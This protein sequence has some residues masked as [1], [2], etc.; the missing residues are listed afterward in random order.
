MPAGLVA[1]PGDDVDG[2]K[3]K[4]EPHHSHFI[5]APS[6]DWGG[7]TTTMI[8]LIHVLHQSIPGVAVVANGGGITKSEIVNVVRQRI[9]VVVI[10]GSGRLADSIAAEIKAREGGGDG[11]DA[12]SIADELLR[13][14]VNDGDVSLVAI[15]D[16]NDKMQ[17]VIM[18]IISR[19]RSK[20]N[21]RLLE[22]SGI[23]PG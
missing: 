7:E 10:T 23:A 14:I 12:S 4:L 20:L 15:G 8:T 5:F 2:D 13:E 17:A 19:E 6:S 11:W 16:G 22:I 21:R 9:P 3:S 18:G 1:L